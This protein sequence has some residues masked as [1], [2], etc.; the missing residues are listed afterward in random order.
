MSDQLAPRGRLAGRTAVVTGA[1]R[2]IGR[3]IVERFLNEGANVVMTQRSPEEGARACAELS[4]LHPQGVRFVAADVRSGDSLRDVMSAAMDHYGSIDVLCNN[5]GIGLLRAVHETTDE[6]YDAV[7]DT[8]LRGAFAACRLAIPQ[9]LAQRSG[10]IVNIASVAAWVGFEADAAYCA[11]KG[12]LVAL[13]RQMALDFARRGIRVNCI[14]PGFVDTEM[15]RVFISSHDEPG[16]VERQI[17][18]M[19]PVGRVGRPEEIAAAVAFLASDEAS[20]ITGES[21]AVDGGLLAR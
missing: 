18:D 19:H 15:M 10:S 20:F 5:A 9:M 11:S 3:A 16:A 6:Q 2:G 13:S 12:A 7:L 1:G 21:L 14:C 4:T 17:V 8:N